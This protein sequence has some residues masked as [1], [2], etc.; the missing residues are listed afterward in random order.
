MPSNTQLIDTA[1]RRRFVLEKRRQGLPYADIAAAAVEEFGSDQLP[2]S[3]GKR[4]AHKDVTRELQKVR[5]ELEETAEDVRTLELIRLDALYQG[6]AEEAEE[7]DTD[8]VREARKIIKRRC[9]MLG[10]DEPEEIDVGV[11][12]DPETIETL[13]EALRD[14]PEARKAVAE[15]LEGE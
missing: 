13:L 5:S 2:G 12:T 1:R 9:R 3:W 6:V 14:Y 4:Y 15:A 11:G 10:I 8:A 7:G